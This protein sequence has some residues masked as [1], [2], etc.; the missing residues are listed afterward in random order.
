MSTTALEQR[1]RKLRSESNAQSQLLTQKLAESQSGQNLLHMSTRLSTLPPLLHSL[2][3]SLHPALAAVEG[4]ESSSVESLQKIHKKLTDIRLVQRR[5]AASAECADLYRDVLSAERILQECRQRQEQKPQQPPIG[6]AD[7]DPED[8][9]D[10][11]V[12]SCNDLERVAHLC[13]YMNEQV[14]RSS[15]VLSNSMATSHNSGISNIST[16]QASGPLPAILSD[17]GKGS[18]GRCASSPGGVT[19]PEL[20]PDTE[21]A[22]F[23]LLLAPRIRRIEGEL[24]RLLTSRLERTLVALSGLTRP[25]LSPH[26][27]QHQQPSQLLPPAAAAA[28]SEHALMRQLLSFG[29]LLRG[30]LV[31]GRGKDAERVF[32][33]VAVLPFLSLSMGRLDEGGARGECAGLASYLDQVADQLAATWGR[34]LRYALVLDPPC[35]GID[36]VTAGVWVPLVTTLT[37]DAAI[38]MAIFSPGI[39]SILQANY[40]ALDRFVSKLAHRLLMHDADD[41]VGVSTTL[42]QWEALYCRPRLTPDEVKEAQTRIYAHPKTLDFSKK[43]NLPIY[44]QLRFGECCTRM[45]RAIE[46]TTREGWIAQVYTGS[47]DDHARTNL[48][49]S[50]FLELYDVLIFLWRPN[51]LLRPLTN[52]FLRGATQLI[53]RVVSFCKDGLDGVILFGGGSGISDTSNDEE[54][55]LESG[56]VHHSTVAVENGSSTL[57][58]A[59]PQPAMIRRSWSWNESEQDVGAVAWELTVLESAIRSQY[60]GVVCEAL[61]VGTNGSDSNA[62][63]RTLVEEAIQDAVE[64]VAPLVDSAWNGCIVKL[65]TAKCSDPLAA[66]KGVAATYRMTNRPPPTQA[67][68]Y[69]ATVLRPLKQFISEFDQ[70]TPDRVGSRWKHQIVATVSDRYATAVDDLLTTVQRT[71]VALN[72]RRARRVT[73]GGMSDGD[74]VKLQVYLDCEKYVQSIIEVAVDP[75]SVIG[76]SKLRALTTEGQSLAAKCNEN[77]K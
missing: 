5:S 17:L 8:E 44:Y 51:V 39:A 47:A 48:E 63:L 61:Q 50:L 18:S 3:Q 2:V 27:H 10:G 42:S 40:V 12:G 57:T 36:L 31:L 37:A 67:S 41:N 74:K 30:F 25:E 70:R 11:G 54:S 23:V 60:A 65:L 32:A 49:L 59:P 1:L 64:H 4:L 43:W 76:V 69:V 46:L 62:E 22:G 13:R 45:N 55:M 20:P 6:G 28:P 56:G 77:G 14:Q 68:P 19:W 71:E 26:Q 72:S 7:E 21:R 15:T 35:W 16:N 29:S 38:Q 33:T 52:R 66:V 24:V 58:H 53:G 9:N 34:V 73:A 75:G